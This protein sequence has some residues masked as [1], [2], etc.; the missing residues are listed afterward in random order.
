MTK[1][2]AVLG[3][4]RMGTCFATQ[5]PA[6]CQKIVVDVNEAAAKKLADQ[7]GGSYSTGYGAVKDADVVALVLPTHLIPVVAAEIAPLL[8]DDTIV[9]N[10]ATNGVIEES[11]R[12]AYPNIHFVD[13]KII[14]HA[15]SMMLGIPGMVVV[16]TRDEALFARIKA[17]LPGYA[18]AVMG[19]SDRVKE[20]NRIAT[21]EGIRMAVRLKKQYLDMGVPEAWADVAVRTVCA[22]A[23]RSYIENDLGEFAVKLVAEMKK[24]LEG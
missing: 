5:I 3:A 14:G 4:G 6:E 23:C 21:A 13:S 9:L 17:C 12:Q 11:T 7:I 18:D 15:N 10:L 1:T 16:S 22:G 20:I 24:E 8:R 19:D 2:I